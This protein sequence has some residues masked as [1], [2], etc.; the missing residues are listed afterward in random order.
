MNRVFR[1]AFALALFACANLLLISPARAQSVYGSIF[2][3]VTDKSGAA[4]PDA[5][6]TVTDEA[7]GTVVN[8]TSNASGDY[9]VPHLIPDIYDLKVTAKG[10]K[11]FETK[12]IQVQADTAPRIDPD[13]GCGRRSETV[14]VNAESQ[15]ELKTD[16][17]DVATVFDQQQVSS[18]PVGDQ[19]FTNLQLLLPGAQKLGWS[20]AADENPQ[21]SQQIQVDGQAF[22]GTA[23]ELDGTDNQDPILGIIVI[24]P[25]MDAVTETK[26]T[27]QNFDAELGKAV[28]AV[29]TAQTR[30]GTNKLPRQRLRFPHR[31]RQP[32]ARPVHAGRTGIAPG[33][34]NRFGGSIGGPAIKDKAFFFGNYEAQR[35][36]VGTSATDTVPTANLVNSCLSGN[37]CDFSE[38]AAAYA[39]QS[40]RQAVADQQHRADGPSFSNNI[41][42]NSMLSAPALT[43]LKLLQ[44]YCAEHGWRRRLEN[45]FSETGTGLFNS[46]S[47]TARGDYTLNE[48]MHAFARFSRFTDILSGKVMFGDAGGPGF[49]ISN[50]GGNSKGANDSLASGMDIAINPSLLTDFRL[51]YYRYNV[52][53]SKYSTSTNLANTWAS[54]GS[55]RGTRSRPARRD[56]S[57]TSRSTGKPV[58]LRCRPGYQPLQLPADRARGPVPD[59][60]QL[61]QGLGQPLCQGRRGPALRP[62]P[63]R[64][65]GHGSRRPAG[66][67]RRSYIRLTVPTGSAG[68]PLCSARWVTERATAHSGV[69][70][71][72]PPMPRSSR[73]EPSSTPRT[74]GALPTR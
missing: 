31:Q 68:H 27:T 71:R 24:N 20:H 18:L 40:R 46:D 55:T 43:L 15:P 22:G 48:K 5:T 41:I 29:V 67:R 28:S 35:Q 13:H 42:P 34:K 32:G 54:P 66:L 23:F 16:R 6:V 33:I 64:A 52:I 72:S 70:F 56:S 21:G 50:Y 60:E 39:E 11:A 62:Q 14:E 9:S 19:N 38:Y 57:F 58:D 25:A 8:V 65:V 69:T 59:R 36:K 3:T 10:F 61:D 44:P 45:N 37:G 47:W 51:G 17:A 12:G 49:G 7:K 1:T 74:P 26:I 63:A 73:S 2:G 30:S 4:V 53:D